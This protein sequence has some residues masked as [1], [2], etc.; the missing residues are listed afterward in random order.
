MAS[1]VSP[2][3]TSIMMFPKWGLS[4][5]RFQRSIVLWQGKDKRTWKRSGNG[6]E[7]MV[8]AKWKVLERKVS[9]SSISGS[10]IMGKLGQNLKRTANEKW[11][12]KRNEGKWHWFTSKFKVIIQSWTKP[13][14]GSIFWNCREGH[15]KSKNKI[16]HKKREISHSSHRK[17]GSAPGWCR[18]M[19]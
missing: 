17:P 3:K 5:K 19:V 6:L 9:Y 11:H 2:L 7:S 16:S 4:S 1:A 8:L 10:F 18:I 12:W 15:R 13:Q 14:T